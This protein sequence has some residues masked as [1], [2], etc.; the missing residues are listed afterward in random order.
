[1]NNEEWIKETSKLLTELENE[2]QVLHEKYERME[3]EIQDLDHKIKVGHELISTYMNKYNVKSAI[4]SNITLASLANKSYPEMIVEIAKQ[5]NG[6]LNVVDAR[7]IMFKA[8]IGTSRN[9]IGH[10]IYGTLARMRN[11]FVKIKRGQYRFINHIQSGAPQDKKRITSG[12]K[13]AVKELKE[14]NPL[15][16]VQEVIERL[17]EQGFDFKGK[18][19]SQS[20]TMA[21]VSLGYSKEGKQ[22]KLPIEN[23]PVVE[24]KPPSEIIY[25]SYPVPSN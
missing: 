23:L 18:K 5:N 20:V 14:Q 19:P 13:Q 1:M 3:K 16:T 6:I 11:H 7:E 24:I 2:R 9:A 8:N 17:K 22:Q 4:T 25:K 21:W 15:M 12:V 10:S